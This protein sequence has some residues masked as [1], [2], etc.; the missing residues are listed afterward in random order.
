MSETPQR[1]RNTAKDSA[2]QNST[3]AYEA[4]TFISKPTPGSITFSP[5]GLPDRIGRYRIERLLGKGGMGSVYLARD[6]LIDRLVA[7][8]VPYFEQANAAAALERF[9]REAR[10]AGRL[11]HPHICPIYDVNEAEGVHHLCMAYIEGQPLSALTK[12]FC[13]RPPREA[14]AL[15]RTIALALEEAHRQGVIHRDLKP[16]NVM[17]N[18]RNEPVVMD[19][20]LAREVRTG[21]TE[22]THEGTILGTPSYMPPEQVRGDVGAMGPCSDVYSL[23]VVLFELLTG[24]VPFKGNALDVL[25]MHLRDEPPPPSTI[26]PDVDAHLEAICL[27]AMAKEPCRRFLSMAEFAQALDEYLEG[28]PPAGPLLPATAADPLADMIA[29]VLVE[30]RT[31]GWEVGIFRLHQRFGTCS[32]GAPA[33][34]TQSPSAVSAATPSPA[35]P[36]ADSGARFRGLAAGESVA[37]Y[38]GEAP[39]ELGEPAPQAPP[40]E[41]PRRTLLLRWLGGEP[42]Q[43]EALEEFRSVRQ[44]PALTGWALVGRA[45]IGNRR[46]DFAHV[47]EL[48]TEAAAAGDPRDHILRAS[49]AHQRGFYHYTQG[50]LGNALTH[51]LHALDA[52]GRDHFLTGQVLDTLGL[53]YARKNN[54]QAAREFFE[55]ARLCKQRFGDDRAV[56][57]SIRCLGTLYLD[58]DDLDHAG[59]AFEAA[60]ELSQ[61]ARDERGRARCFNY[62]GRIALALGE[63]EVAAGR[64][65]SARR[66]WARAAEWLDASIRTHEARKDE[67]ELGYAHRDRALLH[68]AE[69]QLQPAVEHAEKAEAFFRETSHH[70]GLMRLRWIQGIIER[71]RGAFADSERLLRQSLAHFDRTHQQ[72]RAARMQLEIARTLAEAKALDHDVREAFLDALRRAE[73]CRRT[74]LVR[75]AE[76]ELMAI[77]EQAHWEHVF[78]RVRGRGT[79]A[80]TTSLAEGKSEL[81]TALFLNLE[82]F[83]PF[84]Q[85]LDPGEVMQIV[86]QMMADLGEALERHKAH[87]TA[88]LGGGFMALLRDAGH[89]DRAVQAALDL[90]A[91]AEAF[92]RP[93]AVL[94]LRQVPVRIGIATGTV[95]MGNIGT[96]R[97]MDFT[98][99]GKPVNLAAR[100]MRNGNR[101]DWRWPCISRK[102]YEMIGDRFAFAPQSPRTIELTEMGNV[103]VWDVIGR[104]GGTS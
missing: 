61:R 4:P 17:M 49:I 79:T 13:C 40:E 30:L 63:R 81:A 91:V 82:A 7:L 42:I 65:G 77:D 98:A 56:A 44:L 20:G 5:T 96:Y 22:Q 35:R 41:N 93:R 104:K 76:E 23:G 46:H 94:G 68:L 51:L 57:D 87:V 103:E 43:A 16:A 50:Q 21:A 8:K 36:A 14:A 64:R 54:V 37:G 2:D 72:A 78:H 101:A 29:E 88:Y 102:T 92:N 59:E 67:V 69:D 75:D 19:F 71:R 62:L 12:D 45:N 26:R 38:C 24:E 34:P 27:K 31:W 90:V 85:G 86:N 73:V 66:H 58:W 100:L 97:R 39:G 47:E 33:L 11:Q 3:R 95:S 70:E 84:C 25:A 55:Q 9:Y 52:C 6:T 10:S 83:V 89:A 80:D 48:L 53:L 74:G 32:L 18:R 1:A 28:A 15:V 60:L 99:I